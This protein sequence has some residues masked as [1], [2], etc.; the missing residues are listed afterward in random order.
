MIASNFKKQKME[1]ETIKKNEASLKSQMSRRNFITRYQKIFWLSVVSVVM[2]SV[3]SNAQNSLISDEGIII[4]GVRWA[5][6]NVD[7]PGTFSASQESSGMFYQWNSKVGWSSVEPLA[8]SNGDMSWKE[9]NMTALGKGN[10]WERT[11]DPSPAGWRVPNL[12]EINSLFDKKKVKNKWVVQNGVAGIKF[13][14]KKTRKSI[15]FP[16]CGRR[17]LFTLYYVGNT[18][19]YWGNVDEYITEYAR[20]LNFSQKIVT[21]PLSNL[22]CEYAVS[23]RPVAIR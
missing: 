19:T 5:T 20:N 21:R 14:D 15:F 7:A 17:N 6:R 23:I 2:C 22:A 9:I 18:G 11:N 16:A 8:N 1:T 3:N 4:N 13:T 10:F 12:V